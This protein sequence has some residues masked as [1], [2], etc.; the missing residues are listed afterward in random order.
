MKYSYIDWSPTT[1]TMEIITMAN[2]IIDMYS[3]AGYRLTLR[4]IYYQFVSRDFIA[5]ADSSYKRLG[6]ILANARL[7]GLVDWNAIEDRSRGHNTYYT[8]EN[9]YRVIEN[10]HTHMAYDFWARQDTYVEVWVE[11]DALANVVAKACED[12]YV[13]Y[14]ACKGYLSVS[15]MWEAAQRFQQKAE[16]GKHCVLMHLGDH[17][18]SG[19][20]M[21]RDNS[22]R[23]SL[24][25]QDVE[26][27]RIALNMDQ[28]ESYRP[29]PNP[30]KI[31]DSRAADYIRL[32]G[33]ESWE[34]DALEPDVIVSLIRTTFMKYIDFS[35]WNNTAKAEMAD[36]QVFEKLRDNW[37]E[38]KD[39]IDD[40]EDV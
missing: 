22:D 18:P 1:R 31:S 38:V 39:F 23:L 37:E 24:F 25:G 11:K 27:R 10:L 29:P 40:M 14:M 21:T 5:N 8:N 34:L 28:V 20:D 2:S 9:E 35:I 13:I 15:Q 12:Y 19:I 32:Y 17:D 4:Q 3:E 33:R 6:N 7:A 26:I 16:E 30:A 36:Q